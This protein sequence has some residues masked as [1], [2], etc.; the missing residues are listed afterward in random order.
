MIRLVVI[1]SGNNLPRSGPH[2][3]ANS[4]YSCPSPSS[5]SLSLPSLL[6][7]LLSLR[8]EVAKRRGE[9][10]WT[11]TRNS[12]GDWWEDA[13]MRRLQARRASKGGG[14]SGEP[15][16]ASRPTSL[17]PSS[18]ALSN[19]A[20][21]STPP[22]SSMSSLNPLLREIC[23]SFVSIIGFILSISCQGFSL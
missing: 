20:S 2:E 11:A 5:L 22:G 18:D 14:D 13:S 21:S 10:R 17:T 9:G 23:C 4:K 1:N 8:G 12:W 19:A 16:I 7:F 6:P 3:M 15:W